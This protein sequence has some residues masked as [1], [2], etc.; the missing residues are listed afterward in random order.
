MVCPRPALR[1]PSYNPCTNTNTH[2]T[3]KEIPASAM[4]SKLKTV[5]KG[6]IQKINIHLQTMKK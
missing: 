6:G 2:M 3:H 4:G 1:L 5:L